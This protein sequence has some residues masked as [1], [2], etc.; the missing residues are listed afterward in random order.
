M[1][2]W[3]DGWMNKWMDGYMDGWELILRMQHDFDTIFMYEE[4]ISGQCYFLSFG[5]SQS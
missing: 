4:F 2:K 5:I 3:M 1:D